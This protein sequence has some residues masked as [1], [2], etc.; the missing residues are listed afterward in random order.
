MQ[1]RPVPLG[2]LKASGKTHMDIDNI[3][4]KSIVTT[5]LFRVG[6]WVPPAVS[7]GRS[8]DPGGSLRLDLLNSLGLDLVRRPTGGLT[9]LHEPGSLTIHLVAPRVLV[10]IAGGVDRAGLMLAGWI[11]GGLRRL[12]Y[13]VDTWST[14]PGR[15]RLVGG[16]TSICMAYTGSA[17][18]LYDG[19]KVGAGALRVTSNG[20]LFQAFIIGGTPNYDLWAL[21]DD[22]P[23]AG[24]LT[25]A[26]T[27]LGD[28][29]NPMDLVH[30]LS[31][32]IIEF[33][34]G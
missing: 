8:Q 17:D 25:R 3:L 20:L 2:V 4:L 23:E 19:L 27:G 29:P 9:I 28:P 12:G 15:R 24:D 14:P 21:I 33:R 10:D 1:W 31:M 6:L 32:E 30:A 26:F 5:P 16:S 18:I 11:A 22:Y 13:S 7:I 34:G